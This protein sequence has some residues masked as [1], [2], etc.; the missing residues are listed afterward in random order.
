MML[1]RLLNPQGIAGLAASVI[2]SLLLVAAKIDA[3]H[4]KK[5]SKRFEQLYRG[6]AQAHAQTVANYRIAAERARAADRANAERVH[7][8]QASIN[9]RT[10]NDLQ[11]R[12]AAARARA[13]RLR[14]PAQAPADPGGRR[15]A[16]VPGLSASSAGAAEAP[17]QDRLPDTDRLTATEQAI[18]LDELIRWVRAQAAVEPSRPDRE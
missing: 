14:R 7:A 3:H 10:A 17:G 1:F 6:E 2:L 9:E 18:Q 11:A 13:D 12:L 16:P 5:Q 4:W 15:V 8:A